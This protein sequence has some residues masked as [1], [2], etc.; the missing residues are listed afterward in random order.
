[1]A[2]EI[3]I[4]FPDGSEA[5]FPKGTTGRQIAESI[6]PGLAKAAIAVEMNGDR[7][8]LSTPIEKSGDFRVLT[9]NDDE[10]KHIFWHSTAHIMAEAVTSLFPDTKVAI[11]PAIDQGFYYDFDRDEPFTPEDLE[12]IENRM[13][14]LISEGRAFERCEIPREEAIER[15]EK[16]GEIYK[17]ELVGDIPTGEP[18][19]LYTSGKFTDLC[20][21]P[22]IPDASRIKAFKLLSIAGA[23]WRGSEQNKM[24]QR[25]YGI[26]FPKKSMLD[27]FLEKLEE[28]KARDHRKLGKELDLFSINE[29]IG[30]GLVLW[31]PNGAIIRQVIEDYWRKR[32]WQEGYV[33]VY[34]P[35]V[36]K[37]RIWQR[38]GHLDFYTENMYPSM[39]FEEGEDYYVRP[40]NCP[41]HI[42]IYKSQLR[43][44]RDLPIRYCELGADY[45]Y[46]RSGVLQGL[47][48]VRGFTMDDAHIF[49]TPEQ[50]LDEVFKVYSFSLSI[51]RDFGFEDFGI[52][53]STRPEKFVGEEK[54][55]DEAT[56]AL[57]KALDKMGL[58]YKAD[59][60]GGAFY[61]PKIDVKVKD[62]LGREWQ[63]TTVQF[64]FNE[65]ER[66][67]IAYIDDNGERKKQYMV[68]R[69]LL[70][71]IERFFACLLEHYAGNFPMWLAPTQAVVM[72]ISEKYTSYARSVHEKLLSADIR[73][74]LDDRPE[75]IA[76]RIRDAE[77]QKIP[78]ML[79]VGEREETSGMASLRSHSEGD[80]GSM[81][82]ENVIEKLSAEGEPSAQK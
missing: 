33:P 69:A 56:D 58:P 70:G 55:W 45:R 30:P 74:K 34:T 5:A 82:L 44:Y 52:Y 71:S 68:H 18:V 19:S 7:L 15:F 37:A 80:L 22:H 78:Y 50:M 10:G 14:E 4:T 75:T 43:S 51:M 62:A 29:D 16:A 36:G 8:D 35:H 54:R 61:G 28:A 42:A 63:T 1:M 49:C 81:S 48:R 21:G 39:A 27:E 79:I 3:K 23:Y 41:F 67:D 72:P 66:F 60:G 64:D 32:H 9:F 26:S 31:H 20:R 24:L 53:L 38:S 40:M 12:A 46:E 57:R 73:A 47:L 11:G 2:N 6:G 13:S 59:E 25:I 76:Y 17:V 65:P 77:T